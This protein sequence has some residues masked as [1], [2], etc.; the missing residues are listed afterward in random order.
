MAN[1]SPEF[2]PATLPTAIAGLFELNGY[3]VVGPILSYGGEIDLVATKE[4]DLFPDPIY[5]EATVAH[6]DNDKYAHDLTKLVAIQ[7]NEPSAKVVIVSSSGFTPNVLTKARESGITTWTYA[8]LEQ[9][10]Q[11]F[12]PYLD[13]VF[14][15]SAEAQALRDLLAVYEE[16]DFEDAT[17][18]DPA[19]AWLTDW[20]VDAEQQRWLIVT[21][22][23]GTGKT[24]LTRVL[25]HRWLA[26][27]RTD[28][29]RPIPLRIE[30]RSF[31]RQFDAR[32]LLHHFLD[33][34]RLGQLSIDFVFELIRQG[35]VVLLLDGYDE[36]AQYM[37]ARE[38]RACLE[39]LAQLSADGARG[40]LTSRPNYF[41]EAEE[42]EV[43]DALYTSLERLGR[44]TREEANVL[45]GE[46]ELD[47]LFEQQI[48]NRVER[49][50]RDLTPEQTEQ[51]VERKLA[52]DPDAKAVVIAL[53]RRIFTS[54]EEGADVALSG[55][56]VIITYLL[57][58]ADELKLDHTDVDADAGSSKVSEWQ[59][60]DLV[61]RK[62]MLRD[63]RAAP[64]TMPTR[65]REFLR[66]LA[67]RL[68]RK[69]SSVLNEEE[70][71]EFVRREFDTDLRKVPQDAR[72]AA[73]TQYV[74][75]LR[76]SATL[77]RNMVGGTSGFRFSHNSL[78]EFLASEALL[79]QLS[80]DHAEPYDVP[81]SAAM[82]HFVASQGEVSVSGYAERLAVLWR[83]RTDDD[84][85]GQLLSLLWTGLV[86]LQVGGHDP[87]R[88]ALKAITGERI[89]LSRVSIDGLDLTA[90]E[91]ADLSASLLRGSALTRVSLS[92]VNLR[93]ASFEGAVLDEVDLSGA[94]LTGCNFAGAA[95]ADVD[96]TAATLK[97]ADF[98]AV[99][100][101]C[102][103]RD[104]GA[105]YGGASA[106]GLLNARGAKTPDIDAIHVVRHHP[107]FDVAMKV[108]AKL[109]DGSTHQVRGLTQRGTA[110][111]DP[112]FASR[113]LVLCINAE[114][115]S[116]SRGRQLV[117]I[118]DEGRKQ[119]GPFS[120]VQHLTPK[121]EAI[122]SRA[123][124][125]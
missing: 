82:R 121:M 6:V 90:V 11:K 49:Q 105:R 31:T 73:V 32:G 55:K 37:S 113:F 122:F 97:D 51:L 74:S 118:T 81:I 39:A 1:A 101:Q 79:S 117:Q 17:G 16:P 48:I 116:A 93:G 87:V 30:L 28:S 19:T 115:V 111:S 14:G 36:M 3:S 61:V 46:E 88:Q 85:V 119:L 78:R 94:D 7:K 95:L 2:T 103:I 114:F 91:S 66:Q 76:R 69:D 77:T 99:D 29:T 43:L 18:R 72:E 52:D 70:F 27:Y 20:L 40:I 44:L 35:R 112:K 53:L 107:K 120:E 125:G 34:N 60:Y 54:G 41:S 59:V 33:T 71:T 25:L 89:D 68:S 92:N 102:E 58:I 26:D 67:L 57:D 110:Q 9:R 75:D 123:V 80:S 47:A 108:A 4:S 56:P 8:Q 124:R 106:L 45:A 84:G 50:L 104:S 42:L 12:E 15:D 13:V 21:G 38:R 5:I 64:E 86:E 109:L 98:I 22:E 83:S 24:A 63:F 10:F 65:R 100:A 96:I 23:Y 62:L